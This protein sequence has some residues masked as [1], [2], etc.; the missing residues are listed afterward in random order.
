MA[1]IR[2]SMRE[3]VEG[4]FPPVCVKC[5]RPAGRTRVS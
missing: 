5:G 1:R 3:A 2:V 4:D